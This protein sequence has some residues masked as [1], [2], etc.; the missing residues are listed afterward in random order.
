VYVA[1]DLTERKKAE[2][3]ISVTNKELENKVDELERFSKLS[4]GRELKM[5]ELKER[6]SELE[7]KLRERKD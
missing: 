6:I 2:K 7:E 5:I 4:V 1:R 3:Q